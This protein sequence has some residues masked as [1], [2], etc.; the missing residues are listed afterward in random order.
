M[1]RSDRRERKDSMDITFLNDYFVPVTAGICLCAGY[2]IKMWTPADNRL[3][4]TACAALGVLLTVWANAW[5]LSPQVIL[6]GLF[7]GLAGTGLHE[8]LRNLLGG[9]K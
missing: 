5:S 8:A 7:S 1:R 6:E 3:I 9:N 2:I 4:P